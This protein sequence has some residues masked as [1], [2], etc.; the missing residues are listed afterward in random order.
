MLFSSLRYVSEFE[1][2]NGGVVVALHAQIK[3]AAQSSSES[4]WAE[5]P[6]QALISPGIHFISETPQVA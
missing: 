6:A 5:S 3:R 1:N 4:S 2:Q